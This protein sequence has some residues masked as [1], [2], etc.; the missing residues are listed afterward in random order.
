MYALAY[1]L[2]EI[3]MVALQSMIGVAVLYYMA[4]LKASEANFF[5]FFLIV[6]SARL[7]AP[8]NTA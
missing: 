1:G 8:A 3:P 4:A 7:V 5:F 6:R 2:I